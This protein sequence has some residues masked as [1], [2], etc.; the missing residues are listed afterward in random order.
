MA[1]RI[2]PQEL[3]IDARKTADGMTALRRAMSSRADTRFDLRVAMKVERRL[4][5][6]LLLI[7]LVAAWGAFSVGGG[8]LAWGWLAVYAALAAIRFLLATEWV[9]ARTSVAVDSR[10]A[11]QYLA[12]AIADVALWGLMMALVPRPAD[13]LEGP[14]GFAA[15]GVVL[16]AALGYGGW[17]RVWTFYVAAWTAVLAI[18]AVRTAGSL[19][20]FM[21]AFP[22]WLL[23]IWWLGRQQ[24][25]ARHLVNKRPS[26]THLSNPTKFGWQAAIHAMPT[27]VI[28]MRNGR[29]IE[30]NRPAC[31]LMGRS[32]RSILGTVIEECLIATPSDALDPERHR[33]ESSVAVEARPV[34]RTFDGVTW[35]GRVR[36]MEPGRASSVVVIALTRAAQEPFGGG[37]LVEDARR[38]AEWIGGQQGLPWYRDERGQVI[39]PREFP[40]PPAVEP[41]TAD[42]TAFPL[43]YLILSETERGRV[44]AAFREFLRSGNVFDER[45][46]LRDAEA[47]AR[48]VRV[49]CAI[50]TPRGEGVAPVIGTI[51]AAREARV[52]PAEPNADLLSRLPVMVWLVDAGGRLLHA[53]GAD[54]RKW[55]LKIEPRA[56]P[57]WHEAFEFKDES[58][59]PVYEALG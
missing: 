9:A 29:V 6:A 15:A 53:T 3:E 54:P 1:A 43:A 41:N 17:P 10:A 47:G 11:R 12:T 51:A 49:V 57:V 5:P 19:P 48:D 55:G 16:L 38:F 36:Y 28:V 58:V 23:A 52:V 7:G 21:L 13:F 40:S 4:L 35:S 44:N 27:P 50:G 34:G 14:A 31:E 30:V 37:R 42:A 39:V 33:S 18:A 59:T 46:T 45:M 32:E 56:R 8:A 25:L 26:A 2:N 24:P 22:L 20:A